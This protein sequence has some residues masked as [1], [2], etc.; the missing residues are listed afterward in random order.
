ML[1][2]QAIYSSVAASS[3]IRPCHSRSA[4]AYSRQTFLWTYVRVSVGLSSA[5]CKNGGSDLDA[6]WHHRSDGSRNEAGS[7]VWGSVHG[8]GYFGANLGRAVVTNGDFTAYACDS[9][10][11]WPS[12]QITLGRLVYLFRLLE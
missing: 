5:L 9:A 10:A 6:V 2:Q 12:S 3:F 8:K 11:T 7:G 4:A 1:S